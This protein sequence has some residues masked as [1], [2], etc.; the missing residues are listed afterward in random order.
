MSEV[1]AMVMAEPLCAISLS[2]EAGI[3]SKQILKYSRKQNNKKKQLRQGLS[4]DPLSNKK[5][6]GDCPWYAK[7][8]LERQTR[9]RTKMQ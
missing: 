2:C 1:G 9:A 7:T 3:L 4:N 5:T 6:E 8:R